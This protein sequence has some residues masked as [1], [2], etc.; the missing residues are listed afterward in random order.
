MF[1]FHPEHWGND[2][3]WRAYFSDGW[4]HQLVKIQQRLELQTEKLQQSPKG[5]YPKN[6]NPP[7]YGLESL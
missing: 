3:I 1:Y 2:P 5:T 6:L 7:V 4:N